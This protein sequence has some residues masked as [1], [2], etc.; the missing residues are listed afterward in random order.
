[1]RL[2]FCRHIWPDFPFV[3]LQLFSHILKR[4]F[5]ES[6][7]KHLSRKFTEWVYGP[8]NSSLYDLA[9]VDSYEDN[10]VLEI[11]IYG[12]DIPV[13]PSVMSPVSAAAD[14][15]LYSNIRLFSEPPRD[16]RHG[17]SEPAAGVKVEDV[18]KSNVFCQLPGL[19]HV[20]DHLHSCSV[21]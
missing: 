10:S 18:C 15:T 19:L 2:N 6:H 12:T 9:S 4:E 8:V 11:L 17:A 21:Q 3:C 20:P 14:V 13:S 16:A 5:H 7:T 1:M